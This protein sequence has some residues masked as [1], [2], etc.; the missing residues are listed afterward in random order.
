MVSSPQIRS[1]EIS[2]WGNVTNWEECA[3]PEVVRSDGWWFLP[4]CWW[5]FWFSLRR[6]AKRPAAPVGQLCEVRSLH[7]KS[8]QRN[9][10]PFR[11]LSLTL[12]QPLTWNKNCLWFVQTGFHLLPDFLAV[13]LPASQ[14]CCDWFVLRDTGANGSS[15][16]LKS[17]NLELWYRQSTFPVEAHVRSLSWWFSRN[18]FE[19]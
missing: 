1:F 17:R 13:I 18:A 19:R 14:M 9:W 12:T 8:I 16:V 3:I 11:L 6:R 4:E 15:W 10:S 2:L 7:Y 5:F